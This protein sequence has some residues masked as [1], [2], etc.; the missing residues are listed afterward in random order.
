VSDAGAN[1]YPIA[2]APAGRRVASTYMSTTSL[3]MPALPPPTAQPSWKQAWDTALYGPSGFLRS[4]PV[5]LERDRSALIDFIAARAAGRDSVV[6]LGAAAQ[7]A[8]EL[9]RQLPELSL[10]ADLP[11]GFDG[12]T[13]AVDWLC[14]VP[15]HVVRADD[16]GRPRIV[17]VDPVTGT[18]ILGSLVDDAG[19]PPSIG[20]WLDEHWPLPNAFD[21]AEVGTTREAAW[22]DVVRRMDQGLAIAV[23]N[24]HLRDSRPAA[25]SLRSPSGMPPLPDGTRDLVADVALD[26]LA[27][28]T[29][30]R[31]VDE[32]GFTRVENG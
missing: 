1:G 3:G 15:T 4:H 16:D 18:E 20:G 9:G 32:D 6:L 24:G 7:L 8:P 30:G 22:R 10:R 13:V 23:E 25:G 11:D 27:A 29:S 21:R 12:L 26:A 28:A 5:T 31:Y 17:H 2:V 19:V 14:H